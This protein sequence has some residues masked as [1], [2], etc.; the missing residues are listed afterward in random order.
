MPDLKEFYTTEEI[1]AYLR[2]TRS[3]VYKLAQDKSL[4]GSTAGKHRRFRCKTFEQQLRQQKTNSQT[5]GEETYAG[6]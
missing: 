1:S 6:T 4:P 3:P 5:E 2:L